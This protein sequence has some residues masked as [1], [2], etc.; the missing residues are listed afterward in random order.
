[1]NEVFELGIRFFPFLKLNNKHLIKVFKKYV[2]E[3]KCCLKYPKC[4]HP[5]EQ[6]AGD[7]LDINDKEVN[8]LKNYYFKSLNI[9][10]GNFNIVKHSSWILYVE[11]ENNTPAVWHDH[12]QKEYNKNKQ[13]SG[14]CYLTDTKFGTEF[15]TK[16]FKGEFI[17]K[18]HH[19]YLWESSLEHRP[20]K[21]YTKEPRMIVAT[22][23][24]IK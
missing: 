13:I 15:N 9:L 1:M 18:Q 17:P 10:F 21:F 3:N 23:T 5:K 8:K 20:K 24:I 6:S 22:Y 16:Y 12:Y 19:W 2:D 11:K 4:P 14:I 7:A